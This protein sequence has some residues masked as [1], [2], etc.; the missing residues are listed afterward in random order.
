MTML[1]GIDATALKDLAEKVACDPTQASLEF[2]VRSR[3][4]GGAR[5]TARTTAFRFGQRERERDFVIVADTAEELLGSDAAPNPQELLL[6]ALNA[7]MIVGFA[8]HATR[9]GIAIDGL[10]IATR[11]LLDLRRYLGLDPW[12]APGYGSVV[13]RIE[14]RSTASREQLQEVLDQVLA[15]SPVLGS[16]GRALEVQTDLVVLGP[17]D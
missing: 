9:A 17:A 16:F 15:S 4:D 1:N 3:W 7:S 2:S 10:E 13:Q 14:V 12:L 11:G 5:S 8:A 6:A